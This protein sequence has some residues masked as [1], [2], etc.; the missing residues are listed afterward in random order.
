MC[1]NNFHVACLLW[2]CKFQTWSFGYQ[3]IIDVVEL[4][5]FTLPC[6]LDWGFRLYDMFI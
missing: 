5:L 3:Q 2:M 4:E 6:T 1:A